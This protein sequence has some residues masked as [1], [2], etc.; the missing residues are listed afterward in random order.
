MKKYLVILLAI[1]LGFISCKKEDE[2][3]VPVE[4]VNPPENNNEILG[5]KIIPSNTYSSIYRFIPSSMVESPEFIFYGTETSDGNG[6]SYVIKR[7]NIETGSIVWSVKLD[8]NVYKMVNM[9][10]SDIGLNG[11]IYVLFGGKDIDGNGSVEYAVI[12]T[13]DKNG[14]ILD[15]KSYQ[16]NDFTTCFYTCKDLCI[17]DYNTFVAL[18]RAKK[19]KISYPMAKIYMINPYGKI[20]EGF[21]CAVEFNGVNIDLSQPNKYFYK[22]T[23]EGVYILKGDGVDAEKTFLQKVK[24]ETNSRA[25]WETIIDANISELVADSKNGYYVCGQIDDTASPKGTSGYVW[26]DAVVY[27]YNE[28]GILQWKQTVKSKNTD[29]GY[30]YD[31]G[32][33]ELIY[34]PRTNSIYAVGNSS[35]YFTDD[36][37]YLGNALV[38]KLNSNDGKLIYSYSLGDKTCQSSFNTITYYGN[39]IV[40]GGYTKYIDKSSGFQNWIVSLNE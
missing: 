4:N 22:G 40:C 16:E 27:K 35:E 18:G 3:V 9:V 26:T 34:H 32:F 12:T 10:N 2:L 24:V 13:V 15:T 36:M 31:D 14:K 1:S 5:Q 29:K 6:R 33:Q 37:Y 21:G 11:E 28:K 19:N 38:C 30:N 20:S 25:E 17:G 23:Q 8:M 7:V 39:R